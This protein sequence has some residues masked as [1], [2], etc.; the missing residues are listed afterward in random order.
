VTRIEDPVDPLSLADFHSYIVNLPNRDWSWYRMGVGEPLLALWTP[1]PNKTPPCEGLP[2][3]QEEFQISWCD[4]KG[5][6]DKARKVPPKRTKIP[7]YPHGGVISCLIQ[8]NLT[9]LGAPLL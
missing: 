1:P 7:T 6:L 3:P 5:A 9:D 4:L 2:I 8:T